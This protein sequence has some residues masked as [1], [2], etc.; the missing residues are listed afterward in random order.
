MISAWTKHLKS[1]EDKERFRNS[2]LGSKYVLERLADILVGMEKEQDAIER[3]PQLYDLPNWD[4]RQAHLNGF[5]QCLNK[6]NLLINLDQ[7]DTK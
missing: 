2:V 6:I 5:R 1:E 4:Y 7:Q 3:N